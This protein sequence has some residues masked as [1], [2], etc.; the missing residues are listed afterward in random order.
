MSALNTLEDLASSFKEKADAAQADAN[1]A[2][3]FSEL[4]RLCSERDTWHEAGKMVAAVLAA[5]PIA[6][7]AP[8]AAGEGRLVNVKITYAPEYQIG[9]IRA[10]RNATGMYL[11]DARDVVLAGRIT[12]I[13]TNTADELVQAIVAAGGTAELEEI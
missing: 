9:V 6:P 7:A 3:G 5:Q 11:R 1:S 8:V 12:E 13:D 4:T 10:V 2:S